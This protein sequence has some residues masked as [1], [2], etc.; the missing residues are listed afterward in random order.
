MLVKES[1]KEME[2][3]QISETFNEVDVPY[4][5]RSQIINILKTNADIFA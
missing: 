3:C 2:S 4:E 5:Y 1:T